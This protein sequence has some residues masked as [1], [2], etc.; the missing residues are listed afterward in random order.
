MNGI[1]GYRV[2]TETNDSSVEQEKQEQPVCLKCLHPFS[3]GTH[4]CEN[5]GE[6]VGQLTPYIPFVNIRFNY[7]IFGNM[8]KHIWRRKDTKWYTKIFYLILI[9]S[10][11]PWLILYLPFEL[12]R[13]NKD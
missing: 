10:F 6:A 8:W 11:V 3:P 4:Y 5:C 13:K 7:S 12:L 9:I 2:M 1:V